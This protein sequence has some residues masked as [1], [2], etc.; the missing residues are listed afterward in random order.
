MASPAGATFDLTDADG[1]TIR[2]VCGLAAAPGDGLTE[3]DVR[4]GQ[5]RQ[6]HHQRHHHH[7]ARRGRRG[8]Q[9]GSGG[10]GNDLI[11]YALTITDTTLVVD[12]DDGAEP[13][14]GPS[15]DKTIG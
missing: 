2:V 9:R 5:R 14:L 11:E 6:R 4:A 12:A 10:G 15:A 1:D 3:R 8:P 7:H 13:N